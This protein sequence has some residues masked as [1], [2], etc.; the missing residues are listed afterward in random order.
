M[1][2]TKKFYLFPR[3]LKEEA[4]CN[5][6]G[7]REGLTRVYY[8]NGTLKKEAVYK[9]GKKDGTEKKYSKQGIVHLEI[10]YQGGLRDG[11]Y[12]F[13][14]QGTLSREFT[15]K[16]DRKEGPARRLFKDGTRFEFECKDG[17][18]KVGRWRNYDQNGLLVMEKVYSRPN[19]LFCEL[20][21]EYGEYGRIV[22]LQWTR[23][24]DDEI[25]K[26]KQYAREYDEWG[27]PGFPVSERKKYPPIESSALF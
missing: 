4:H 25:E 1:S 21:Y 12:R 8:R 18:E 16:K 2:I 5:A 13:Y 26:Y 11:I 19:D 17:R 22:T 3:Q 10:S 24:L 7:K 27:N 6:E 23:F 20:Y 9:N 14:S 15:Y